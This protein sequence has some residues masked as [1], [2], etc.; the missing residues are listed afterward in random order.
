M[1]RRS[2]W[3]LSPKPSAATVDHAA[4]VSGHCHYPLV[5]GIHGHL[6]PALLQAARPD[7]LPGGDPGCRIDHG[8]HPQ[9]RGRGAARMEAQCRAGRGADLF[10]WQRRTAGIVAAGIYP[11]LSGPD[12]LPAVLSRLWGQ[13]RQATEAALLAMRWLVRRRT[14][15]ASERDTRSRLSAAASGVA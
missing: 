13:P 5:A 9:S 11:P 4:E 1:Q 14:R 7:L 15:P 6:R 8:F 12:G 10:R 3:P 2:N